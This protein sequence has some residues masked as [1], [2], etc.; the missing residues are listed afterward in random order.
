M[1]DRELESIT[2]V[3]KNFSVRVCI[4]LSYIL[5]IKGVLPVC[6]KLINREEKVITCMN[7]T[8]FVCFF[9]IRTL[10][11]GALMFKQS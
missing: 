9:L 10:L 6:T 4:P 5:Q 2:C 3:K 11:K 7:K 1:R 8:R